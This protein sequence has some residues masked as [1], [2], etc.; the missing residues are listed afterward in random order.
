MLRLP[1][2]YPG[3]AANSSS[4]YPYGT[5]RNRSVSGATDG[6][7]LDEDWAKDSHGACQKLV[8]DAGIVPSGAADTA[9]QSDI[10][11]AMDNRWARSTRA[12]ATTPANICTG[13][14][15]E[16]SLWH[17]PDAFPNYAMDASATFKDSCI[18]WDR[19]TNQHC[20]F[21]INQNDDI[22]RV[23]GCMDYT[24][25]PVIGSPLGLSF[26]ETPN[27]VRSLCCDGSYLYVL[28]L[29]SSTLNYMVSAFSLANYPPSHAWTLDT[30]ISDPTASSDPSTQYHKIII[31]NDTFLAVSIAYTFSLG[32]SVVA[33]I[34]RSGTGTVMLG[35]GSGGGADSDPMHGRLISDGDH[36]FWVTTDSSGG[37]TQARLC[38]ARISNP[39]TS[40]YG[41]VNIGSPV[42]SGQ[43]CRIPCGLLNIGNSIVISS[44]FGFFYQFVKSENV[45]RYC[46]KLTN[47]SS[48]SYTASGYST[49]LG[50]D[51]VNV[52]AQLVEIFDYSPYRRLVFAKIPATL[53]CESN[54]A[55]ITYLDYTVDMVITGISSNVIEE[56]EAGRLLFDGHDMW[57]CARDGYICRIIAPGL[58]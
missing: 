31:A 40:D 14:I 45:V 22:L 47:H 53:F 16:N 3:R 52:W 39:T 33:I 18:G 55:M 50:F 26:P 49:V 57:Y 2:T 37:E 11:N 12:P 5:F 43:D 27:Q 4:E 13:L 48:I 9:I 1:D 44:P 42:V 34:P 10:V 15:R 21:V 28:W 41:L 46:I 51:G 17:R 7:P 20:L 6:T 54:T 38:S 24:Y 36:V 32:Y 29:N 30:S 56:Y 35:E 8:Q 19:S 25:A 23:T 58:R